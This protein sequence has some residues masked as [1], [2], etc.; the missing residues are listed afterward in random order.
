MRPSIPVDLSVKVTVAGP[1][2]RGIFSHRI[3]CSL[4]GRLPV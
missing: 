1:L 2:T 3:E 4:Y